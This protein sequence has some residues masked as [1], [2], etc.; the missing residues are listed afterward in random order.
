MCNQPY[1]NHWGVFLNPVIL[2]S[3]LLLFAEL[4][5]AGTSAMVKHL[6]PDVP[7]FHLV[8]F[9]NFFAFLILIPWLI[10]K[11]HTAFRTTQLRLHIF[12]GIAGVGAM[13][14]FFLVISQVSLAKATLV[15]LM[16]PF[17]IPVISYFWLKE[18]ISGRLW[19]AISLGFF[20]V[21]IFLNPLSGP[22]PAVMLLAV[23]AAALAASTKTIIR[24]MASTESPSKIV[25]Y[26]SFFATVVTAIPVLIDWQT[27]SLKLWLGVATMGLFAVL[28]QLT[29]T[30]A[31]S[32]APPSQVGVFTYSSVLFAGL[33][34]YLVWG[35]AFTWNMFLGSLVII[36]AG[37]AA[38]RHSR[39][40]STVPTATP[41]AS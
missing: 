39:G 32:I 36:A 27:L 35:E 6:T 38:I 22:L 30:R 41:P 15:L 26:F 23:L 19:F 14:L 29:M 37:Y 31:F 17:L 25:F 24:Q 2:A 1:A 21:L 28:G 5:F 9:R 33:I 20:G 16:A 8:F 11:R 13:Y 12:R 4:C 18:R 10:R 7:F 3:A 40:P 34:G